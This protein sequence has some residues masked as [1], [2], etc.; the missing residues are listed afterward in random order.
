DEP[1]LSS[2]EEAKLWKETIG[3]LRQINPNLLW[4]THTITAQRLNRPDLLPWYSPQEVPYPNILMDGGIWI[5][6]AHPPFDF[7]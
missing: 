2:T 3:A 5:S 4:F 7:A 6:P 1:N